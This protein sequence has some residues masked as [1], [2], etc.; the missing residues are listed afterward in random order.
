MALLAGSAAMAADPGGLWLVED[1]KAKVRIAPCGD[2]MCGSVVWLAQP[3]DPET[4]KPLTDKL[5]FDPEKRT[6]PIM[7]IAVLI[8]MRGDGRG[9]WHGNIYNPE[10]GNIYSGSI[11]VVGS[12]LRVRGCVAFFCET[13]IWT[14]V[15]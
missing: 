14:R 10:D 7:G 13:R 12:T 15:D 4:G 11:E 9:R 6:R 8:D 5:N 1:R 3:N 2:A